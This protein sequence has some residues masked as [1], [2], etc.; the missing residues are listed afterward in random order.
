[1]VSLEAD[2]KANKNPPQVIFKELMNPDSL[3][4]NGQSLYVGQK[5]SLF[6]Y[7]LRGFRLERQ[8][9]THGEGPQEFMISVMAGVEQLGIDIQSH[10]LL[11]NSLGKL[12]FFKKDGSFIREKRLPAQARD[13]KAIGTGY[14]GQGMIM[15]KGIMYRTINLYDSQ[16][17]KT[18]EAVR[19]RHH[20]Q[21]AEG[22]KILEASLTFLTSNDNLFVAWERDFSIQVFDK[23]GNKRYTIRQA[24]DKIR[25]TESHKQQI[26]QLLKT[27]QKYKGVFARFNIKLIFPEFFPALQNLL[28][29][30][31]RIYAMTNK[32]N[33]QQT[34]CY[35]LD[36]KGKLLKRIFLP[37]RQENDNFSLPYPYTISHGKLYQLVEKGEKWILIITPIL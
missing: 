27:S 18:R 35:V 36:L 16:F 29:S 19:V 28:I 32:I 4:V 14:A 13:F 20:F 26:T 7:N 25:V 11:V 21:Q 22:L 15:D 24:V 37:L 1:M 6:I 12:S 10:H 17:K 30:D 31:Q 9:G 3:A 23:K 34:E 8:I 2:S 5:T 33:K